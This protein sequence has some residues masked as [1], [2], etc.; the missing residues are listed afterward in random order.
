MTKL[1]AIYKRNIFRLNRRM[2]KIYHANRKQK[3]A[4]EAILLTVIGGFKTKTVSR[5]EDI[6]K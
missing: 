2:K 6:F 3:R 5:D 4:G 1:S